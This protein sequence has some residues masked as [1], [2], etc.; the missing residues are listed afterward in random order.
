M[1]LTDH[2]TSEELSHSDKAIELK[3]DNTPPH[4]VLGKMLVLAMGLE[5]IRALCGNHPLKVS[6]GY[7]SGALNTAVGSKPTSAHCL[8]LA[9]DFTVP[10]WGTP[11]QIVKAI[12][13]SGLIYDQVIWECPSKSNPWVH[14]SF[15]SRARKMAL[16]ID[17]SGTKEWMA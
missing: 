5:E 13:N 8:G 15:D 6:S 4:Y 11:R 14:I 10:D 12:V 1:K 2:F 17:D 9:A 16:V 3:I 7:R